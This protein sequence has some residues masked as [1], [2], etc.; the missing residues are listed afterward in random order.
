MSV[1]DLVT[2]DARAI[3]DAAWRRGLALDPQMLVSDWADRYRRLPS[4]SAEPGR[5]RTDRTPYLREIMDALST[6]SAV[7]RVVFMK[8][9]Q[10]GGTEAGLNWLGYIVSHAPANTLL[11]MP[12]IDMLRRNTRTRI[13]PMIESTPELRRLV[14]E[15]KSREPG[16]TVMAKEFPGGQIVMTGANAPTG[17]R[18]TPCRFIFADEV[19]AF[20]ADADGEGDPIALAV[21]RTATFGA[22]RKVFLC[23]TPTVKGASRI[24]AAYT[25]SDQRRFYVPCPHCGDAFVLAWRHVQWPK[26]EHHKAFVACPTCGGVIEERDKPRLLAGG[27]WRATAPGDGRTAGFHVSALCSPFRTWAEI[28]IAFRD[29]YR[30]P[31]RL[32]AWTNM[33]LGE[34]FEDEAAAPVV[35]EILA[36]RAEDWAEPLPSEIVAI[37][38]GVDV[39]GDRLEAEL[40]GWG[41]GE[42]SWSLDYVVLWGDPASTEVWGQLDQLLDRR[43]IS[44]RGGQPLRVAATAIDSGGS[45]TPE[46]MRY[47]QARAGRRV[48]PIKGR[49]GEGVQPWPKRPPRAAG[50]HPQP[51]IVGVDGLKAALYARLRLDSAGPGYVHAPRDRDLDWFRGL[52]AERPIRRYHKGVARIDWLVDRGVRNEPL[53]CRVYA[54]AALHGLYAIGFKLEVPAP[55]PTIVASKSKW[56]QR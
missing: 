8:A 28:A 29:S 40:V 33:E 6:S 51:F 50:A 10:I 4:S 21:Q 20:P 26:G 38:A 27:E 3:V 12:T 47:A 39:Q 42:E 24:E 55:A 52:T 22:R 30:Q 1:A 19:D 5:W 7:E 35:A 16:N 31:E 56:M 23:S 43:F 37:T 53:D 45:R 41:I 34:A 9:A 17:L 54:T 18:S 49:G 25:E 44:V 11:V 15:A 32:K 46:V 48:W 13:D 2:T 36:A 14:P